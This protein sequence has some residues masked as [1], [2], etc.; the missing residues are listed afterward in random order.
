MKAHDAVMQCTA[1]EQTLFSQWTQLV[2]PVSK[3]NA[4]L[5]NRSGKKSERD[6]TL[7]DL[8]ET[9]YRFAEQRRFNAESLQMLEKD[10]AGLVKEEDA[11]RRQIESYYRAIQEVPPFRRF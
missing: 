8:E 6:E 9:L 5:V 10:L 7:Q 3:M 4:K 2:D 11:F 1:W